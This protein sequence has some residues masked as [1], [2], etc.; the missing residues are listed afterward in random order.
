MNQFEWKLRE[1]MCEVARRMYNAGSMSGS[2]RQPLDHSWP[3]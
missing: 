3:E 2:R 1:D